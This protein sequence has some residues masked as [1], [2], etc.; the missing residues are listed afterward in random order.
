MPPAR[1]AVPVPSRH[2][3]TPLF[4][5]VGV[6]PAVLVAAAAA[7]CALTEDLT[8][9]VSEPPPSTAAAG[10][11][12]GGA[13]GPSA[14]GDPA[15]ASTETT[16]VAA[17]TTDWCTGLTVA[18]GPT[19]DDPDLTELSGLAASERSPGVLWAVNDSGHAP[20]LH[21]VGADG[22]DLGIFPLEGLDDALVAAGDT[23]DL[24]LSNGMVYLADIG[25]NNNNRSQV[26]VYRFP[27]PDPADP[28]PIRNVEVLR[29]QY[30]DGP[31]DAEALLVDPLS[32]ELVIIDKSFR[33]AS[34][35]A[36]MLA[37]AEAGVYT[38]RPPFDSAGVTTLRAAGAVALDDLATRT[39]AEPVVNEA[40]LYGLTGVATAADVRPDGAVVAVRTYGTVWL[41]DRAEGQTI[42]QSLAGAPCEAPTLAEDQGESIAFL[43]GDGLTL[44]TGS[45][46]ANP[47]LHRIS[48]P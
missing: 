39:T 46:G 14:P 38:A 48:R 36:A 43:P 11:A 10:P 12:S 24:A 35:G 18:A 2:A 30:P 45:E 8:T 17:P 34:G 42:V 23:E 6:L 32:G 22:E 29:L 3:R 41:F 40:S 5:L 47:E 37:A 27:E 13:P 7:G 4:R 19:V 15:G 25:D 21:A 44:A 16:V 26:V 20:A 1:V 28:G 9:V 31:R 33:I